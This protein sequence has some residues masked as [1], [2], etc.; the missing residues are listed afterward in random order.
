MIMA[1]MT[2]TVVAL[3]MPVQN[4]RILQLRVTVSRDESAFWV[5][6]ENGC[7]RVQPAVVC[8]ASQTTG[9]GHR[10]RVEGA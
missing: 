9:R 6:I 10:W 5:R 7:R 1:R 3:L 4:Y 2:C 8:G